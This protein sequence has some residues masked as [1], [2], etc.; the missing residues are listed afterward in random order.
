MAG[1]VQNRKTF[2]FQGQQSYFHDFGLQILWDVT[3]LSTC[4]RAIG[5]LL[6][7][8]LPIWN[9]H[10]QPCPKAGEPQKIKGFDCDLRWDGVEG[11]CCSLCF[12]PRALDFIKSIALPSSSC[13][14]TVVIAEEEN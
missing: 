10:Y 3:Q 11:E 4:C 14:E 13:T 9:V 1:D 6:T 7:A 5:I 8:Y 2:L 12:G